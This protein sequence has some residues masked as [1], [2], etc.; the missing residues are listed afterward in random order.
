MGMSLEEAIFN[1]NR[2]AIIYYPSNLISTSMRILIESVKKGLKI[3]AQS[4]MSISE[5]LKNINKVEQ[6][7][8][9][10]LAEFYPLI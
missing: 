9:D 6:R 4:L 2:G 5:Y 7:L 1:L 8:K 10:L 3:A